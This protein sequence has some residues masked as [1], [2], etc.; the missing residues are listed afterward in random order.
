VITYR[1]RAYNKLNVSGQAELA[2]LIHRF[3]AR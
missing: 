3:R 2:A 1:Q